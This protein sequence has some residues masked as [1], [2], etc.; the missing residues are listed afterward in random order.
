MMHRPL[1]EVTEAGFAPDE[2]LT[3]RAHDTQSAVHSYL[4]RG[5]HNNVVSGAPSNP[6]WTS[7]APVQW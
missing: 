6:V 7:L 2:L 3:G 5:L 1:L 4:V